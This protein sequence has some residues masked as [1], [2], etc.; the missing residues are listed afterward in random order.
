MEKKIKILHFEKNNLSKAVETAISKEHI[1]C[2]LKN[3]FSTEELMAELKTDVFD[4]ILSDSSLNRRDV[5]SAFRLC[6]EISPHSAFILISLLNEQDGNEPKEKLQ[7]KM[8]PSSDLNSIGSTLDK[9]MRDVLLRQDISC[10]W[11]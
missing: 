8:I 5:L 3:I 4:I 1:N 9:A 2:E 10:H 6:K 11:G 7:L